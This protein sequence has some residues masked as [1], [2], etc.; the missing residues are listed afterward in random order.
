[1]YETPPKGCCI[2]SAS[3]IRRFSDASTASRCIRDKRLYSILS[4]MEFLVETTV[5]E[6]P[7]AAT[8]VVDNINDSSAGSCVMDHVFA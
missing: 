6:T 5:Q 3:R 7:P 8:F 1:V 2:R 4:A